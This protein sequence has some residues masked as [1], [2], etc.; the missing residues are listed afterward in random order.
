MN[1]LS[2]WLGACFGASAGDLINVKFK[3]RDV[4]DFPRGSFDDLKTDPALE[5]ITDAKSGEILYYNG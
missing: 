4:A 1:Y 3:G 2:A 5:W